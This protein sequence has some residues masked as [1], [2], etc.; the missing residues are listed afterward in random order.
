MQ[1]ASV[2][3]RLSWL[4]LSSSSW[5]QK[6]FEKYCFNSQNYVVIPKELL[7]EKSVSSHSN[8]AGMAG[9]LPWICMI[10]KLKAITYPL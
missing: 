7:L 2:S 9:T 1:L 5:K 4:E 6:V 3:S 8:V 10:L